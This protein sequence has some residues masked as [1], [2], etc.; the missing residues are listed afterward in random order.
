MQIEVT[1]EDIDR[2]KKRDALCCPIALA[3]AR[4]T[5]RSWAIGCG[6]AVDEADT[7]VHLPEI[8][9]RFE[10]LFDFGKPVQP[11]SFEVNL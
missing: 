8:A 4:A 1:Q 9:F 7:E 5:G 6:V 10:S 11:L 3:M 2:G